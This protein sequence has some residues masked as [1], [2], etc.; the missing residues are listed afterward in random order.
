MEQVIHDRLSQQLFQRRGVKFILLLLSLLAVVC[1][2]TIRASEQPPHIPRYRTSLYIAGSANAAFNLRFEAL[3]RQQLGPSVQMDT[4][5]RELST[6]H[7]DTLVLTLGAQA[8]NRVQQQQPRPPTLALMVDE[9]RFAP[10]RGRSGAPISAIYYNPPLIEQALL[11]HLILPRATHIAVLATPDEL[12]RYRSYQ[13]QLQD[14]GLELK[15]FVMD[16]ESALISTLSRALTYGDFLLG[17]PDPAIFNSRTVK[18]ILLTA[19][20]RNRIVIGPNRAFVNA[21]S[22]ASVYSPI[23]VIISDTLRY[24]DAFQSSGQLPAADFPTGFAVKVNRQVARS[25]N[26]PL[27]DPQELAQSLRD[28][29]DTLP[30]KDTP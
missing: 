30:G 27:N 10:Y 16:D 29:L 18:H 25:L 2:A 1:S 11:G 21:G 9:A 8:L 5:S 6:A 28:L 17:V 20:R 4:Y 26:I 13:Q 7:P 14:L 22:L 23:S 3:L 24:F 19:Y 12:A 15:V